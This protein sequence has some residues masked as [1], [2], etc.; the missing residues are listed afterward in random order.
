[1]F[2]FPWNSTPKT[3]LIIAKS[4][5]NAIQHGLNHNYDFLVFDDGLQER[6]I[7][8]DIKLVCFKSKNWIVK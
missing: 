5:K 4:R 6:Q 1:M 7:D 3:S 8:F 2:S